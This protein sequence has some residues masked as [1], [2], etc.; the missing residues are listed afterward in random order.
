MADEERNESQPEAAEQAPPEEPAAEAEQPAPEEPQGEAA[1]QPAAEAEEPAAEAEPAEAA[2]EPSADAEPA[3]ASEEG[4]GEDEL[5]G[6]DWKARRR[7]ARSRRPAEPRPQRSPEDR[8]AE[9]NEAR[10]RTAARRAAFRRR[11]RAKRGGGEGTP[12]AE[13]ASAGRKVRQGTVVS[14]KADKTITVRIDVARRHPAYEKIV[15]HSSTLHA[16]DERNEANEGDLV[17]VVETRPLSR[18]KRW[19]LDEILQRAR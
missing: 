2:Q 4:G 11:T 18:T 14:N 1:E 13:R 7:L 19:R 15:R 8:A 10:R 5:E 6:L 12:P 16:H 9:R 3:E 17:R